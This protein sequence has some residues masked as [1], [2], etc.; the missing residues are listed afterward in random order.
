LI[1]AGQDKIQLE[2]FPQSLSSEDPLTEISSDL[3]T[4]RELEKRYT[5]LVLKSTNQN[6]TQAA[7]ILGTSV[8]TLWRR[9]K[10]MGYSASP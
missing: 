9:L 5:R 8:T 1:L 2:H 7:K 6:K 4:F 3:P 10:E